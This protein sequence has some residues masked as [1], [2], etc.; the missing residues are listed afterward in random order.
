MQDIICQNCGSVNDY[1][2]KEAGPHKSAYCNG[3]DRYIKHLPQNNPIS[4]LPFGMYK[5]REIKTMIADREIQWLNWI[6]Q[7]PDIKQNLKT[8]IEDHLKRV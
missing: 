5:G 1:Y 6:L 7:K 4:V 8:A 2:V 3:C